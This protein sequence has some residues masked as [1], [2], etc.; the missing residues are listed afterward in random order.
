MFEGLVIFGKVGLQIKCLLELNCVCPVPFNSARA[1]VALGSW[2]W[3]KVPNTCAVK[4]LLRKGPVANSCGSGTKR[5]RNSSDPKGLLLFGKTG[6][7]VPY[8]NFYTREFSNL[9]FLFYT[10]EGLKCLAQN[11]LIAHTLW[12]VKLVISY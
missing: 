2:L 3:W 1:F 10:S 9:L 4:G 11:V 7:P 8:Q 6:S 5:G 12:Q